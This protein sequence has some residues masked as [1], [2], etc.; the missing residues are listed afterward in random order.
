MALSG[1]SGERGGCSVN[2][3]YFLALAS[4]LV[5]I[6]ACSLKGGSSTSHATISGHVFGRGLRF[7]RVVP[8]VAPAGQYLNQFAVVGH[9]VFLYRRIRPGVAAVDKIY[10]ND[11]G[12]FEF[13]NVEPGE[14][15]V[16]IPGGDTKHVQIDLAVPHY[17]GHF[18]RN[19]TGT[20]VPR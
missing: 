19:Y 16:G 20:L 10:T 5:A 2:R 14:Y 8:I 9:P 11:L 6:P 17:M 12:F 15:L 1:A 7:G 3:R 4:T 18:Q 13:K